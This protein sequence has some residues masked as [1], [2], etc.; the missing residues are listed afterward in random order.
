MSMIG[1]ELSFD[2]L[3]K[4]CGSGFGV[5]VVTGLMHSPSTGRP[6]ATGSSGDG[7]TQLGTDFGGSGDGGGGIYRGDTRPLMPY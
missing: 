5:P 4:V 6:A 1:N 2:E 7:D 3:E